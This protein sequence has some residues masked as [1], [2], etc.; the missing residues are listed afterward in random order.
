MDLSLCIKLPLN[1]LRYPASAYPSALLPKHMYT[2]TCNRDTQSHRHILSHIKKFTDT[3][4]HADTLI[5]KNFGELKNY[6]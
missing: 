2:H 5:L 4:T 6:I 3:P 1:V